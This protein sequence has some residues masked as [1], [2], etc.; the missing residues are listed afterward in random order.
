MT[1]VSFYILPSKLSQERYLFA[2]KLIEKAYRSKRYCYVYTDTDAQSQQ[3]DEQLWEF[4]SSSFIPHQIMSANLPEYE[5]TILIGT[6]SAPEKWREIILNLSS[7]TPV[8]FRQSERILEILHNNE[9]TK[10]LGR[11][12]Y[13]KYQQEALNIVT[14]TM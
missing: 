7:N 13:L 4:R 12:R 5:Q 9:K 10:Q 11:Q 14:H 6:Q 8:N 2:C 3:L 1:E